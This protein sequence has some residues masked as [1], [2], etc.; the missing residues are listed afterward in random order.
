MIPSIAKSTELDVR[1]RVHGCGSKSLLDD[2]QLER[3][4]AFDG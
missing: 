4:E 3:F 2:L 1:V